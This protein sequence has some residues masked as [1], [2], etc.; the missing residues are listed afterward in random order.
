[1]SATY[2]E[3]VRAA[4]VQIITAAA[5]RWGGHRGRMARD[6]G[7]QRTYLVRLIR[8]FGLVDALPRHC[9][10]CARTRDTGRCVV[11]REALTA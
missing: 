8:D 2:H 6:L 5:M 3:Q 9:S 1:V 11:H 10:A 4:R 7:L